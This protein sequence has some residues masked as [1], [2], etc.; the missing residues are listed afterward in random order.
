MIVDEATQAQRVDFVWSNTGLE[1]VKMTHAS[2]FSHIVFRD[3]ECRRCMAIG[4][5]PMRWGVWLPRDC[6]LCGTEL[7]YAGED[8]RR[9]L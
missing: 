4:Q 3:V 5:M 7:R 8:F 6:W 2:S 1:G 9:L